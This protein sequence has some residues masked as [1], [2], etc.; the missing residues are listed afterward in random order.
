MTHPIKRQAVAC[1]L[2]LNMLLMLPIAAA[3]L[4]GCSGDRIDPNGSQNETRVT[5]PE[6]EIDYEIVFNGDEWVSSK[7]NAAAS[8]GDA[9]V[10]IESGVYRL[11][12]ERHGQIRVSVAKTQTVTLILDGLTVTSDRSAALYICSADR[13]YI[14]IP[15][16]QT[17]VLTD[18]QS[19]TSESG[20][21]PNAC[22]YAS[23]DL[24]FRGLGTLIVHGRYNN[25]IGCSNDIIMESGHVIVDAVKNAV[26]GKQSVTL[27]GSADLT[28][29][30]AQDGI[31]SDSTVSGEGVILLEG[32]A[33]VSIR[34]EDDAL[35]AEQAVTVRE[36]ARVFCRCGGQNVHC[37]GQIS[38]YE[39][40]FNQLN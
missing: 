16:G 12:G 26:K 29:T 34:C 2:S 13:V 22:L 37:D 5:T 19:Y 33:T 18:G 20:S 27:R 40:A 6:D 17:A 8:D 39:G 28:V 32:A 23:D 30:G 31:E 4:S 7:K 14:E 38:V 9:V 35:Q 25:G 3:G 36:N 11:S 21:K 15:E 1:L 24:V 10:L